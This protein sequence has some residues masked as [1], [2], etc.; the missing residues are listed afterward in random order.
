MLEYHLVENQMTP[1]SDDYMAQVV[2]VRSYSNSEIVD[3]MLKRGTLLTKADV[4]AVVEVYTEVVLDI[5]EEGSGVHTPLFVLTPSVTGKFDGAGDSFDETRHSTKANISPGT[6]LRAAARRIKTRKVHV[7]DPAP[8]IV[9]VKDSVSGS[10]NEHLTPGGVVE[11]FGTR[12][13]FIATEA[14]NGVYLKS[15]VGGEYKL[16]VIVE[17]KPGRLIMMIPADLPTGTYTL[18]VRSNWSPGGS[19]EGKQLK[20]GSFSRDLTV[21]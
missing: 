20:V 19:H 1:E 10:I 16:S 8:Y 11:I 6:D 17:N 15:V 9:E 3:L 5:T 12:L 21:L 7:E 2:N 14:T 18:E 4:L 13:K